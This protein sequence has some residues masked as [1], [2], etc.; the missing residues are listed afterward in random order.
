[1]NHLVT[2]SILFFTISVGMA[3]GVI[4][5]YVIISGVLNLFARKPKEQDP[6]PSLAAQGVAGD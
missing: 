4:S 3:F 5:G 1:V 2:A 6:A